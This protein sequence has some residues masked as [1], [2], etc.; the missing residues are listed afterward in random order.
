M[1][2]D[3]Y[4]GTVPP[5]P[6]ASGWRSSVKK[7]AYDVKIC[8][9][10]PATRASPSSWRSNP[11]HT[12][13]TIVDDG[14]RLW[15]SLA[16]LEYLDE[17]FT[18]ARSSIPATRRIAR[19]SAGSS[20]RPRSTSDEGI[21]P[22]ADEYFGKDGARPGPGGEGRR[23]PLAEET[24]STSQGAEGHVLRRRRSVGRADLVLYPWSAVREAHRFRKP[25]TQAHRAR[26]AAMKAWAERIEA[27]PLL[28]QDVPGA[29]A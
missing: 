3:F 22:I 8:P 17:R 15:E 25:E 26:A 28:R 21:D 16:I 2:I 7:V 5:I 23:R 10:R 14:T 6:G 19:A 24:A 29:L 27:L 9:S 4:H 11:R 1:A 13:P 12:V 18:P 20:A